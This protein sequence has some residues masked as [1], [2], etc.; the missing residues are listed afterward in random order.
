MPFELLGPL[1]ASVKG[2]PQR[3]DNLDLSH[4][5]AHNLRHPPE[6]R[7]PMPKTDTERKYKTTYKIQFVLEN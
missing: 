7:R 5:S 6:T 1:L 2:F 4:P 3:A